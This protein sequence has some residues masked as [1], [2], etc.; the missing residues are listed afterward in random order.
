ML[1]LLFIGYW[2]LRPVDHEHFDRISQ[3]A[4]QSACIPT[5]TQNS[6]RIVYA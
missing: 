2:V 3:L 5:L 1:L 6:G 4:V